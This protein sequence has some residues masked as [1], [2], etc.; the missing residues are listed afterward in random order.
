[1]LLGG[2]PEELHRCRGHRHTGK[3]GGRPRKWGAVA[4]HARHHRHVGHAV[5]AH[6]RRHPRS[7]RHR[8]GEREERR[9]INRRQGRRRELHHRLHLRP[10][11]AQQCTAR[12]RHRG[13]G[14]AQS[15]RPARGGGI[16]YGVGDD[17]SRKGG[18]SRLAGGS[19]PLVV[20]ATVLFRGRHGRG[21]DTC[22]LGSARRTSGRPADERALAASTATARHGGARGSVGAR[23]SGRVPGANGEGGSQRASVGGVSEWGTCAAAEVYQ[24]L[25]KGAGTAPGQL[26]QRCETGCAHSRLRPSGQQRTVR[27]RNPTGGTPSSARRTGRQM[28]PK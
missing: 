4:L 25:K 11:R 13:R 1:M 20:G 2:F 15:R 22:G 24:L 28:A 12:Q 16:P 10:F 17:G 19:M 6:R 3:G 5:E 23:T 7:R 9:V 26:Q 14:G 21:T 18:S 8:R 27:L